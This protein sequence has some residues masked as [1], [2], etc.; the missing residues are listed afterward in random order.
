MPDIAA[1]RRRRADAAASM[2][3]TSAERRAEGLR[4][5]VERA[6]ERMCRHCLAPATR[7]LSIDEDGVDLS[8]PDR[9]QWLDTKVPPGTY[10]VAVCDQ[11][12]RLIIRTRHG[13][14]VVS[15]PL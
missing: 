14:G 5:Q 9:G 4:Q 13:K 1:A 12:A 15:W 6:G 8:I 2:A 11:H 7:A 10:V 3:M